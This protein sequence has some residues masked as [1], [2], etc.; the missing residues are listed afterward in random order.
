MI[1]VTLIGGLGNQMFQYALGRKLAIENNTQLLLDLSFLKTKASGYTQRNF[2]LDVF[3]IHADILS[4]NELL[5]FNATH[6]N[7]FTRKLYKILPF[8]NN[9]KIVREKGH[10]FQPNLLKI[11]GNCLFYGFWQSEKY[12]TEI[13]D[14]LKNDFSPKNAPSEENQ[15][16]IQKISACHSVSL[17]VRRGDYVNLKDANNF[18]GICGLDYYSQAI[19]HIKKNIDNP[20]FFIFSDDVNWCKEN[21]QTE[22]PTYFVEH[23]TGSNSFEDIRLMSLC[24]HNITANSSF[25]WWGAWLNGNPKKIV[26][27]PKKWFKDTSVNTQD[28]IPENWQRI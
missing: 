27:A 4:D 10:H 18:H 14:V 15:L 19:E 8:L 22:F 17:H 12:F 6:K 23:N 24:K 9:Y 25:S 11:N 3:N 16:I 5:K 7:K 26:I 21:I 1:A 20:V 28:L 13:R 2:E